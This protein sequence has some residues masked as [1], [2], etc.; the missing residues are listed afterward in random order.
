MDDMR[1][2]FYNDKEDE[3]V[4]IVYR[5]I[6]GL[7]FGGEPSIKIVKVHSGQKAIE[8]YSELTGKENEVES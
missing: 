4:L 2:T 6:G 8:L 3:P 1:F 7:V 5:I